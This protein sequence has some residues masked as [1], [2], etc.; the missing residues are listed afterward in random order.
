VECVRPA[1][2]M[3][4]KTS[5]T[6]DKNRIRKDL[7]DC[8]RTDGFTAGHYSAEETAAMCHAEEGQSHE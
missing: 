5:D 8:D 2:A 3:E 4:E 1:N 6:D 7:D